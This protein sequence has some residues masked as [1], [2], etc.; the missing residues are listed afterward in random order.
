MSHENK[1]FTFS[2]FNINGASTYE[3]KKDVF[4]FIRKKKFDIVFLQETHCKSEAENLVRAIWGYNCFVCGHSTAKKGV[5][6]LFNNSFTYKV[7]NI[8]KDDVDGSY[9]ILDIS[10]FED[11]FT[12]AN[13]YGP[14]DKDSPDF[15]TKVFD[16]IDNI[17]NRQV[18]AAGDF[19]VIL[20]PCIDAR[21]YRS[22]CS[23]PRSRRIIFDIMDRMDLVDIYR[24]VYPE[25]RQYTWR[26]FNTIQ[27]SRLDFFL[28]SDSLVTSVKN[29]DIISGYRSD[30]SIVSLSI[31]NDMTNFRPKTYWKFNNTLLYDKDYVK[32]IK[33]TIKHIIK[34]Y[35]LPVYNLENIEDID[36]KD[37]QFSINDQL[38][39]EA[40]LLEIRGKTISFSSRKKKKEQLEE[41]LLNEN[42]RKLEE[43]DNLNYNEMIDLENKKNLLQEIREKK[44]KGMMIRSRLQWLQ[45]GEKP[46]K[47]FCGL[48]NRNFVSKRMS[49]IETDNN[50]I[51]FE[52]EDLIRE[53]KQFYQ[54]LYSKKETDNV[55]LDTIIVQPTKLDDVEK[56]SLEGLI[57]YHEAVAVLKNM[58]NNKSPGNSGFTNEFY[59]FFFV[60]IGNFLVR[61]IN[62]GFLNKKLSITQRQGVITCLPKE[63]K[64]RQKLCNWRP[65]SLLNVQYKI[66]SACI[67]ERLKNVLCK[68][69]NNCQK[70]FISSRCIS[71]NL[72]LMYDTLVYTEHENIPGMLMLIDFQKAFDCLSWDFIDNVLNFLNFGNDFKNWVK[73]FYTDI[74]SCVQVN[75]SYS[76]Y[77]EIQRGVRQGD[78]LSPYLFLICAQILTYLVLENDKI[79]GLKIKDEEVCLSQFADD[80]ALYLDGTRDSF[81]ESIRVLMYYAN[82]SGLNMNYDKTV[83]VWL[84]S[85]KNCET[86]YMRDR[87]FTWDPG[88]R[89]DSKFKYLGL[90]FSTNIKNIVNLNYEKK[91]SEIEKTLKTWGK[92]FLTPFGKITVIKTLALSK[93]TYLFMNLPDPPEDFLKQID[94][95]FFKF[96]WNSNHH[97]ISKK[98]SCMEQ[99]EGGLN[100]VNV[101]D[102]I[103][104]MKLKAIKKL[105]ENSDAI[106]VALI[107]YPI[108]KKLQKMSDEY[109]NVL[110]NTMNN[111]FWHDVLKHVKRFLDTCKPTDYHEFICERI[112]FNKNIKIDGH[113]ICYN[114][115]IANNVIQF[116][117]VMK[118]T[119]NGNVRFLSYIEFV[120][121]YPNMQNNFLQYH[122]LLQ[123]I[124]EYMTKLNINF[125]NVI[126]VQEPVGWQLILKSSKQTIKEKLRGDIPKHKSILKWERN[127]DNLCWKNIYYKCFKSTSDTKLKWFQFRLLF[128]ILPTNRYLKIMKIK[129][130]D[131]CIFC[132]EVEETLDHLFWDCNVVKQFWACIENQ[133]INNLPHVH[134]LT[135]CKELILFGSKQNIYTDRPFDIMI[136]YAKFFIWSSRFSNTRPIG[137]AF[138][139]QLKIKFK[140][141]KMYSQNS[142]QK[143]M[144]REWAPYL[145]F[146]FH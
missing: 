4:D 69:V 59:K 63:G 54:S 100:M 42:I 51:L 5:A 60:D 52:Q 87:N 1:C 33:E 43:K 115:F 126:N 72:R 56:Q 86:R 80:T 117:D 137:E 75:G 45:D 8:I 23:R 116:C 50:D 118:E 110:I 21:N 18:V 127:F 132:N 135:L 109:V 136:L 68:I 46:S 34:Q 143:D 108:M 144:H 111:P 55:D 122:G 82:I 36:T 88:G 15:F 98:Q 129:D 26:R 28:I 38:F 27:Q 48:E 25:K 11:R 22:H 103:A 32:M 145:N 44:I 107:M 57:S 49:F 58:K 12:L 138:L 83:I 85:K 17:G 130:I 6:I 10:I 146:I 24:K 142:N 113:T 101:Y 78:P 70:G 16:I 90:F 66:A 35:C 13:I 61:S 14:S 121:K 3:K 104:Q 64:N 112:F 99:I 7:H 97:R 128:R 114:N 41:K 74:M 134:S 81:E 30:H 40:L 94:Q 92:R 105:F 131:L 76:E 71:D 53:T 20:N 119:E 39:F 62:Y 141:E 9:I 89:T 102:F 19:N 47:Y 29:V 79:K 139:K 2:T 37:I 120:Q 67:A 96:L 91:Y 31:I 133:F 95:L 84:G 77:F 125:E 124:K 65:I 123:S 106:N 73:V 140:M 93:L